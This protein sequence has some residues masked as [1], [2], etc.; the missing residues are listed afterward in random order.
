MKQNKNITYYYELSNINY[1]T[2]PHCKKLLFVS[3]KKSINILKKWK[4]QKQCLNK[5]Y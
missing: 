5:K 3:D 4:K 1:L 2:C